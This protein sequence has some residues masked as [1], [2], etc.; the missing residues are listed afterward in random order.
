[1]IEFEVEREEVSQEMPQ[2][3]YSFNPWEFLGLEEAG[4]NDEE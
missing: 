1:L 3:F 4:N 2:T